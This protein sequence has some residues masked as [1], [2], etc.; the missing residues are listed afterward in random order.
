MLGKP[1]AGV[2]YQVNQFP[3]CVTVA[4]RSPASAVECRWQNI[5]SPERLCRLLNYSERVVRA[6][7][8][9]L[10]RSAE[11]FWSLVLFFFLNPSLRWLLSLLLSKLRLDL[12]LSHGWGDAHELACPAFFIPDAV[13]SLSS[14]PT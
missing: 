5:R 9:K 3:G 2:A 12:A 13:L 11:R 8:K 7:T 1:H 10:L 4:S 14:P 6:F